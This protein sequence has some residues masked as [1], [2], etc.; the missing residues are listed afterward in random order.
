MRQKEGNGSR[1]QR[2]VTSFD[3]ARAAGVSRAAVSRAFTPDASVSEKTRQKVYQAAKELGYRVN[4]LARSLTNKR[5]D[6]V[7]L[8]AAGLDNPFRTQQL[9]HLAR[10]LIARN[11]RPIL[12]PTSKEADS[13]T[14]IG[15][16]LHYAVS[17]VIITSDAPPSYIFEECAAEGV[18]VVLVNKGEDFPF[19]DRV[20]SDDRMSGYL[21]VDHLLESGAKKLAVIAGA[22]VSYSSRRRAEA[23]QARCQTLGIEHSVI[24][25]AINDYVHGHDSAMTLA[26]MGIDGVFSVNDYMACGVLDGLAKAGKAYG[27]V[28]VIGHDDIP[29]A[30]WSAYDLTT[31]VQPCDVQAEQVIDLLTSR[32][33]EPDA[34]ARVEFTPVTLIKRRSA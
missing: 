34:V 10:A 28:K 29:Q 33:S 14:V 23:F 2:R 7:G 17:G 1:E 3:V 20:V 6:F 13:A 31:F 11:Y 24:P 22:A 26:E 19:V 27:S 25:V 21:A 16:L 30:S 9:D 5:S 18:P 8:V 4:Y 32:M 15:Q 12:L